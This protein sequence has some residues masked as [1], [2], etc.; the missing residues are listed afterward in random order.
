[1]AL[2]NS[3]DIAVTDWPTTGKTHILG[4]D[5]RMKAILKMD[6]VECFQRP[7]HIA[8]SKVQ[9]KPPKSIN[10][11]TAGETKMC[12][13]LSKHF[14]LPKKFSVQSELC[15]LKSQYFSMNHMTKS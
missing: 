6:T 12:R 15:S 5:K 4:E 14:S 11:T 8:V 10:I 9:Y 7:G 1:M 2:C 3:N 13:I